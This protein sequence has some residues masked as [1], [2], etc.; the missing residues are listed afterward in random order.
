MIADADGELEPDQWP[1][2]IPYINGIINNTPLPSLGG[3]APVTVHTGAVAHDPL[4]IV[5]YGNPPR[6]TEL[7]PT[8]AAVHHHVATLQQH[9]EEAYNTARHAQ[10]AR[11]RQ[12]GRRQLDIEDDAPVFEVGDFVLVARTAARNRDKTRTQWTGPAVV[13]RIV[14]P[15]VYEVTDLITDG[16][17]EHHARFLKRYSDNSLAVTPQLKRFIAHAG[18][19]YV[20]EFVVAH[21]LTDAGYEL[22]VHWE[23]CTAAEDSWEPLERL[24][25][26]APRF[27]TAYMRTVPHAEREAMRAAL[28][29]D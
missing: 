13:T 25:Q 1:L 22:L 7:P 27:T 5:F 15:L 23:G 11:R 29:R 10:D 8:A 9:L 14:G 17:T 18:T 6:V 4:S 19:G 16:V 24:H 12:H 20:A 21:R 3:L 2:V 26:Q 28:R